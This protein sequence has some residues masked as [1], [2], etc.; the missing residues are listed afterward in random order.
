MNPSNLIRKFDISQYLVDGSLKE[1]IAWQHL[2]VVTGMNCEL[3]H[4]YKQI[5]RDCFDW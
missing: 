4:L 5:R 1:G 3:K 2:N